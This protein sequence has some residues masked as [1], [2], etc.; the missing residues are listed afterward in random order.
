[1]ET[2]IKHL[3]VI[4]EIILLTVAITV[5]GTAAAVGQTRLAELVEVEHVEY[6]ELI[7]YGLVAGLDNTGDRTTSSRG[8]GFTVQ[9]IANMLTTFGIRVEPQ[10][11]Q[12]RNVAAVMVT[13]RVSTSHATG[14]RLSVAVSSLGDARSLNGGVLLQTPLIHPQTKELFAF[15]QG[16]L[17]TGGYSAELGGSRVS[18]NPSLTATI[19]NGAGVV[20]NG[21]KP[22]DLEKPLGLVLKEP[23]HSNAVRIARAINQ[24]LTLEIA[25]VVHP[26]LVHV[27]WP[28]SIVSQSDMNFFIGLVLDFTI[29][30]DTPARV[31]INERTGT[32]VAGGNVI[33]SEVLITHGSIRISSQTIPTV[34]Q[35]L[36]FTAGQTV[37]QELST[38]EV[39][40]QTARN[41]LLPPQTT[42]SVLASSLNN[43]GLTPRDIISIFQAI[44]RAGALRGELIVL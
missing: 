41:I 40:E 14:S 37:V 13:A 8:S 26:G 34:S 44:D 42:V 11:L 12:T 17:I 15:A 2:W 22:L 30:V 16:A 29:Q 24:E 43:L 19:P 38:I 25:R 39:D 9:S 28:E 21:F 36:P 3:R 1:M 18:S 31:V 20:A 7:G 6:K 35:P 33:I 23:L 4:P 5:F 32:I 27:D 10:N